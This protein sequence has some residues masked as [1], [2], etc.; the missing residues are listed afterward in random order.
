MFGDLTM[1]LSPFFVTVFRSFR[2]AKCLLMGF[3]WIPMIS[4]HELATSL[5]THTVKDTENVFAHT[6]D[7]DYLP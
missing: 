6:T 4:R 1:G 3:A 7:H 5:L 2:V